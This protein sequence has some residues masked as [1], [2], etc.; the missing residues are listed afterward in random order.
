MECLVCRQKIKPGE[1][2]F[3][4]SQ[5]ECDGHGENDCSYSEASEGLVGAVCLLCLQSP[6]EAMITP[7]TA[8]PE[9]VMESVVTRSNALDAFKE[10]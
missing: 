5:M 4:G 9:P 1:Q 7:N 8:V 10:L 6:A 3:W 2:V